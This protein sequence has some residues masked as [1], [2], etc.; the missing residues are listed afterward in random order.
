MELPKGVY[1]RLITSHA[2]RI[3]FAKG[4]ATDHCAG[5]CECM[6]L[7]VGT[8]ALEANISPLWVASCVSD[9]GWRDMETLLSS[10]E[11]LDFQ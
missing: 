4:Q 2:T 11:L 8:A 7:R 10:T 3:F 9:A 5:P 1:L 6:E